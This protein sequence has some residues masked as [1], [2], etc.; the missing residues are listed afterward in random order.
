MSAAMDMVS[1]C[2]VPCQSNSNFP[3]S[4]TYSPPS[5]AIPSKTALAGAAVSFSFL[6]LW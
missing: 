6:V 4:Q 2:K 3:G 5:G 1:F